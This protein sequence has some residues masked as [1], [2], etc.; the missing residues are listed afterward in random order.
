M[1]EY[2]KIDSIWKRDNRGVFLDIY[3]TPEIEYLKDAP[4]SWAEKVDGTNIRVFSWEG[5]E[6][7]FR[8]R[9]DQAKIPL[10]LFDRL[11]EIFPRFVKDK[12]PPGTILFGEGYGAKIQKGGGNYKSDGC[13]FVLFDVFI[14]NCWMARESL[15]DIAS[16]LNL[17]IVP[18]VG[19]GTL[20]EASIAVKEGITSTWG[21]FPMEGLVLKPTVELRNR[22]G[23]RIITKVKGKDFR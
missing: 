3:S 8:G 9:T 16:K 20:E 12:A 7:I 17:A 21:N 15:E 11:S 6:P 2:P 23:N 22:I 1:F 5:S 4:W 19:V 10:Y 14:E 13:D 18:I